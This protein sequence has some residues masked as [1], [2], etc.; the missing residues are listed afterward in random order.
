MDINYN[1]D[2]TIIFTLARMN[3]PTPGHLYLI[4][5]LIEEGMSKNINNVYI[6]LSKT[7]DNN[8]NPISCSEKLNILG[9]NKS[10]VETMIHTLIRQMISETQYN[11][12]LNEIQKEENIHK[13]MNMN[14]ICI[15]VPELPRASPFTAIGELIGSKKVLGINDINLILII[16]D[17][18]ADMLDSI[19]DFYF[20]KNDNVN[21]VNGIILERPDMSTFKKL[22]EED[23]L[24][25]DISQVPIG[26]FS[27]SFVRNLVK[28]GLKDKFDKVYLP[29]LN[30]SEIDKLYVS[31]QEGLKLPINKKKE[32]ISKPLKYNYP[33][34]KN[35]NQS[36]IIRSIGKKRDRST[37]SRGGGNKKKTKRK[38]GKGKNTKNRKIKL[39][40]TKNIKRH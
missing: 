27:A 37:M 26:A 29:Y 28:F 21:S 39:Q 30:Q 23:L 11:S 32:S 2:N 31:I 10:F 34:I 16:G 5:R 4:Q 35:N 7:N 20:F 33:L 6:I 14:V 17:D 8:E 12:S 3:P 19:S 9:S 22:R 24:F 36:Q 25:I 40:K 1:N 38:F 13:L 18:R 15:C